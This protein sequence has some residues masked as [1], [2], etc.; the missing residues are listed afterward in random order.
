MHE[1]SDFIA[2]KY[3]HKKADNVNVIGFRIIGVYL[4]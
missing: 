1:D 4:A 2:E 3:N